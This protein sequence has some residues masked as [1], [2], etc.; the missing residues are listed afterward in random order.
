[1]EFFSFNNVTMRISDLRTV[2]LIPSPPTG[3]PP[4]Y[5]SGYIEFIDGTTKTV[6]FDFASALMDYLKNQAVNTVEQS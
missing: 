6:S 3:G 2:Q 5:S 4:Y 1:M